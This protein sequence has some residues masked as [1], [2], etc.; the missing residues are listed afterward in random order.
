M[1]KHCVVLFLL[2]VFLLNIGFS[3]NQTKKFPLLKIGINIEK[4][5]SFFL[6]TDE[7]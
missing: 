3:Q 7:I 1:N 2:N 4:P 5:E 6:L